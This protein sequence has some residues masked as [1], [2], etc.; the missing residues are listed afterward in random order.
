[1][2]QEDFVH[3][4]FW[5][6]ILLQPLSSGC[7]TGT[8]VPRQ[9]WL[10]SLLLLQLQ[11]SD[12]TESLIPRMVWVGW[13]PKAHPILPIHSPGAALLCYGPGSC[14]KH[15]SG[16]KIPDYTHDQEEKGAGSI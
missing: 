9:Q 7:V 11:S 14:L 15:F 12:S 6:G 8:L 4:S 5:E 1:M 13:G 2:E 16:V 10:L 3:P